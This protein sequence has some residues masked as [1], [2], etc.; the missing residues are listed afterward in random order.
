M[1]QTNL[2]DLVETHADALTREFVED[3]RKNLRTASMHS[4]PQDD[5]TRGVR[6]LYQD[7]AKWLH[8]PD[9]ATFEELYGTLS[10][11]RLAA[12]IPL[13][14]MVYAIVLAKWHLVA[15]LQRNQLI[16]SI[17]DLYHQETVQ[18]RAGQFFD[19]AIYYT[20]L[21]YENAEKDAREPKRMHW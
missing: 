13:S 11:R 17:M 2:I 21:G 6:N 4:L 20:V 16:D 12:G 1:T 18:R 5:L 14:E 8:E 3:V 15:Y 9:D 10:R 19:K 7:F